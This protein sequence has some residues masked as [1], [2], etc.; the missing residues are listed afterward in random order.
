MELK[1][2]E[3]LLS[4]LAGYAW[5]PWMLILLCGTHLY[6]TIRN[7]GGI[8]PAYGWAMN[9]SEIWSV[10]GYI[11][12]AMAGGVAPEA[13]AAAAPAAPADGVLPAPAAAPAAPATPAAP[14]APEKK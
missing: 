14:A 8:M 12:K 13:P 4:L 5:G 10:V 1:A 11:R 3:D 6:L 2:L 7:G 9:D